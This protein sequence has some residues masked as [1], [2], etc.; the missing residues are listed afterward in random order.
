MLIVAE[1][2][3]LYSDMPIG[4]SR[5]TRDGIVYI[6]STFEDILYLVVTKYTMMDV[7]I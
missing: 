5:V 2:A 3:T 7:N 6:A 1:S 4:M